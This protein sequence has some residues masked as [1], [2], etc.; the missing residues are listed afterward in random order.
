MPKGACFFIDGLDEYDGDHVELI[1]LL[2][3][4]SQPNN[5]K[6]CASNRP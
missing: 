3:D 4:F 1:R 5:I 2:Q 6:I